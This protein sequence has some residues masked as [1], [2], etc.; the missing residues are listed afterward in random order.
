MSF[1]YNDDV[2][3]GLEVTSDRYALGKSIETFDE[4]SIETVD[5]EK[6]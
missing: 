1:E 3:V 6:H 5:N 2:V 4:K